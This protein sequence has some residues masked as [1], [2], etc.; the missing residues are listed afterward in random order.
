M[1]PYTYTKCDNSCYHEYFGKNGTQQMCHFAYL[2]VSLAK[3]T[4]SFGPR[5]FFVCTSHTHN[6]T[7]IADIFNRKRN[8][9]NGLYLPAHQ[10]QDSAPVSRTELVTINANVVPVFG[11]SFT[12]DFC[13]EMD[14]CVI[15]NT[16]CFQMSAL[17]GLT[18]SP[19]LA[20]AS[21][22]IDRVDVLCNGNV[23]QTIWGDECF[24][25]PN[26][27]RD[28]D[29]RYDNLAMGDYTSGSTQRVTLAAAASSYYVRLPDFQYTQHGAYA[30]LY[31]THQMQLRIFMNPLARLTVGSGTPACTFVACTLLQRVARL[32]AD[33]GVALRNQLAL[34]KSFAYAYSECK[35]QVV[36]IPSGTT[37]YNLPLT[38]ITGRVHTIFFFLRPSTFASGAD[39]WNF[40]AISQFE[41]L[42]SSGANF[43]GGSPITSVQSLFLNGNRISKSTFQT[44]SGINI[45]AYSFS[46]D[47]EASLF[48]QHD[49]AANFSG[50]E[51][52]RI[53]FPSATAANL[54]LNVLAYVEGAIVQTPQGVNRIAL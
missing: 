26:L 22:W 38:S 29:R 5:L 25:L 50:S 17:T 19:A 7:M 52:L 2:G 9:K 3:P 13:R 10:V 44:E 6:K 43:V 40:Q 39:F 45:H 20:P 31:P 47:P 32:R 8:P 36:T 48:G 28:E 11:S 49:G 53:V 15:S 37:T 4:H 12:I 21:F 30:V 24:L 41:L 23:V 42:S 1:E 34:N 27:Q 33:E 46:A 51:Q 54:D 18:G 16:L 35:R 14:T